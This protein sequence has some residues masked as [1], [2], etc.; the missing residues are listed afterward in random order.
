MIIVTLG[1]EGEGRNLVKALAREEGAGL[2]CQ[3]CFLLAAACPTFA[4]GQV[5]QS[6]CGAPAQPAKAA[7]GNHPSS[8]LLPAE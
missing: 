8:L 5:C 1:K 7:M 2:V 3:P 6:S 4:H